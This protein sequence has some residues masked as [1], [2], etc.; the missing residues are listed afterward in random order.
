MYNMEQYPLFIPRHN[1]WRVS[2]DVD[3]DGPSSTRAYISSLDC[4]LREGEGEVT[5]AYPQVETIPETDYLNVRF[6]IPAKTDQDVAY[7]AVYNLYLA[8]QK[9]K[10]LIREIVVARAVSYIESGNEPDTYLTDALTCK[11]VTLEARLALRRFR[12]IDFDLAQFPNSA[13]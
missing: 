3:S 6:D 2:I 1:I 7:D 12:E 11:D 9:T 5:V 10:R 4:H 13:A 8:N